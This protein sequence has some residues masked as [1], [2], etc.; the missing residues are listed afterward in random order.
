MKSDSST[1]AYP[2]AVLLIRIAAVASLGAGLIHAAVAREHFAEWWAYGAFFTLLAI[3][4]VGWAL[5]VWGG[6]TRRVL[7]IGL[8]VNAATIALWVVTRTTGL[9]I[10]PEP[11]VPEPL[12]I[13]DGA[14]GILELAVVVL[15]ALAVQ[16]ASGERTFSWLTAFASLGAACVL[17]LLLVGAAVAMPETHEQSSANDACG[18]APMAGMAHGDESSM[19]DGERHE[20]SELP[21][22]ACATTADTQ[23]AIDLLHRTITATAQYRDLQAATLAGFQVDAAFR[24]YASEHPNARKNRPQIVHVPNPAYRTDGNVADPNVP[25]TLIYRRDASGKTELIGVMYTA[26]NR[27]PGPDLAGPYT[28]WHYHDTCQAPNRVKSPKQGASC[29]SRTKEVI[30]GYMMHVWFV[31]DSDLPYAYAMSVPLAQVN[32]YQQVVVR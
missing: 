13:A 18:A 25:E 10:G 6:T 3:F 14:C 21:D 32:S 7:I 4:Q 29:P 9:P 15:S 19:T 31:Q 17:A 12:G 8:C 20:L 26:P 23:A 16:R 28:R 2:Q 22:V 27:Q 1:H 11:G 30:S 5:A 24:R